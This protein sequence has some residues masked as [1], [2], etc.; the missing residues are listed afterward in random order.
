MAPASTTRF[1]STAS[2]A[3]VTPELLTPQNVVTA[4]YALL[5]AGVIGGFLFLLLRA[6]RVG[7]MRVRGRVG[8]DVHIRITIARERGTSSRVQ[9]RIL[10]MLAL[11][12]Q[13]LERADAIALANLLDTA[14]NLSPQTD[15]AVSQWSVTIA[16]VERRNVVDLALFRPVVDETGELG[17]HEIHMFLGPA[18]A[19]QLSQWLR[20]AATPGRGL[21]DARKR[22]ER[23]A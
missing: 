2:R 20:L 5:L 9:V 4:A 11:E 1:I 6:E 16:R 8:H 7:G 19:R 17:M 18:E 10:A 21:A 3:S 13:R 22:L 12:T 14:S 15:G 23:S